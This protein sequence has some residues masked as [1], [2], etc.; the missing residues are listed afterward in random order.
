M[1]LSY[2]QQIVSINN[3]CARTCRPLRNGAGQ[4]QGVAKDDPRAG[5]GRRR[6]RK[7]R[8]KRRKS[9]KRGEERE[10]GVEQGGSGSAL[11]TIY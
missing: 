8:G 6:S 5:K 7:K 3:N 11:E 1:H 4:V 9:G 10:E 2:A